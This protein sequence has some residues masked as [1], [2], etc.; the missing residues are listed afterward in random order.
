LTVNQQSI[1]ANR[2]HAA[3]F[4]ARGCA[5]EP[6]AR[7]MSIGSRHY[8]ALLVFAIALPTSSAATRF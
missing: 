1:Y 7:A 8:S 5:S 6:V 2:R 4:F 3:S